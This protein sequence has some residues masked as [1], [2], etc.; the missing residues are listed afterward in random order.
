L[1]IINYSTQSIS[2]S[3]IKS[4]SKALRQ[5]LITQGKNIEL[6]ENAICNYL[7]SNYCKVVS[8]GTA[9][10]HLVG[11]ALNWK[12]NHIILTSPISF[13]SSSN[14]AIF[15][16]ATPDFVDIDHK[17]YNID[18]NKVEE[19]IKYYKKKGSKV[20]AV[21]GIDYAGQPCDWISL[22]YLANKYN[23]HLVNDNCHA[24]GAELNNNVGYA[25]KYADVVIQSF[26]AL[27]NI[28]TG[29]GGAVITN[30]KMI[31]DKINNLRSHGVVKNKSLSKSKGLWFYEMRDLGYNYRLTDFQ[32]ALG[33]SQLK[34]I[35]TFLNKKR[36]IA[37]K[38]NLFF[39]NLENFLIPFNAK[40]IKHAYHLYVLQYDFKN[41]N[42][43]KVNFF[44][45]MLKNKIKLQVHYIP[46]Y[47]QPFYKKNFSYPK[48]YCPKAECFYNNSF[49]IPIS[50]NL[51]L[52]EIKYISE[53]INSFFDNKK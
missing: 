23:F 1:A 42:K 9:A 29:E 46:I 32:A 47:Y 53:T 17:T 24:L 40:F 18:P 19:R 21:I 10:L 34:K 11:I 3:D 20:K 22:R 38:Y 2:E 37:N 31:I 26:H 5:S 28:T 30:N 15:C 12:K 27:K 8:S 6:F 14:A 13:I 35:N 48:N 51:R 50:P 44:N 33:I 4:V 36:I 7:N 25:A 41:S 45:Y 49:S 52:E 16:N 43:T 39:K